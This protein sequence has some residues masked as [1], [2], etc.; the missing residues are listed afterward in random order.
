MNNTAVQRTYRSMKHALIITA[1]LMAF[2]AS[3]ANA[4]CVAEY[5]AKRDNPLRLD[6]GT[7]TVQSNTCTADAVREQVR[8]Q[9]AARGWTLLSILSV[10]QSG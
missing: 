9:L 2:T 1:F 5:K 7:V 3:A 6:H 8:S 10:T 4:A